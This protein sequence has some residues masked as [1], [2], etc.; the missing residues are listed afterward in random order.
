MSGRI[1][2]D[3]SEKAKTFAPLG[4]LKTGVNMAKD[5]PSIF[6]IIKSFDPVINELNIFKGE[7]GSYLEAIE[8]ANHLQSKIRDIKQLYRDD[9]YQA[10]RPFL[11][12]LLEQGIPLVPFP[13]IQ[14][15]LGLSQKDSSM[16]IFEGYVLLAYDFQ[17][18]S[19]H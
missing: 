14:R 4:Q 7:D 15:C 9:Q 16:E 8:E 6:G 11:D 5:V 18:T 10:Y 13:K 17:V 2:F 1:E 19:S 3:F 12:K